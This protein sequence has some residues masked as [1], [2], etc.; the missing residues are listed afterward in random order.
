MIDLA[1]LIGPA[2]AGGQTVAFRVFPG[3]GCERW[4]LDASYRRPW[5]LETWPQ[6]NLRARIIYRVA[7]LLGGL[8]FRFPSRRI[9]LTVADGSPYQKFR[10]RFDALGVFLGTPGP[11]RK[12]VVYAKDGDIAWFIKVPISADT[13]KLTRIEAMT[14]SMLVKDK[15]L[16]EFVPRHFWID[17]ALAIEDVRT[18][19]AS[20]SRL[21]DSEILRVHSLLFARSRIEISLAELIQSWETEYCRAV[22]HSDR[23]TAGKI[24]SARKAAR[25]FLG[26]LPPDMIVECYQAHGDFTRWNV[27]KAKDGSPRIIDWELFGPRPKFF[28]PFHYVVSQAI[29]VD[30]E[31]AGTILKQAEQLGTI[32]LGRT[33]MLHYFGA[34]VASQVFSYCL[35]F[36][37]QIELHP[38]AFWQLDTWTD[39]LA[40]IVDRQGEV[41][42]PEKGP[43]LS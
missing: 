5:H 3:R 34:Y 13:V 27:L 22:S 12:F 33:S 17:D 39:L 10:E 4:L 14:L 18:G 21:D 11:N 19:G 20:F 37:R 36:E 7:R 30:R 43:V 29:L 41:E 2:D 40:L 35:I 6:A 31:P 38:Q 1:P 28:D 8:G 24:E 25:A 26:T 15:V 32:G 9:M 42:C 16:A 23:A